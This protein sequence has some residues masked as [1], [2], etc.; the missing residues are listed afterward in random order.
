M[1]NALTESG[2]EEE[3]KKSAFDKASKI[4]PKYD[5]SRIPLNGDDNEIPG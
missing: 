1:A 2:N 3:S 5:Y 4:D